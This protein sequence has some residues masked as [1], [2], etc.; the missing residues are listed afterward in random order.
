[1]SDS[2]S[3]L[4]VCLKM[5]QRGLV[6]IKALTDMTIFK[7][8]NWKDDKKAR[9]QREVSKGSI[10]ANQA[11][12]RSLYSNLGPSFIIDRKLPAKRPTTT[13][14]NPEPNFRD[15]MSTLNHCIVE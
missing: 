2:E 6:P 7:K 9:V 14:E 1:M 15:T 10:S 11:F 13:L 5:Q 8:K 3:A 4:A 12:V